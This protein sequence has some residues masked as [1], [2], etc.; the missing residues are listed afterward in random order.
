MHPFHVHLRTELLRLARSATPLQAAA[1]PDL[2]QLNKIGRRIQSVRNWEV[3][4]RPPGDYDV[5]NWIYAGREVAL[6]LDGSTT[7]LRHLLLEPGSG[8]ARLDIAISNLGP[9]AALRWRHWRVHQERLVVTTIYR[10]KSLRERLRSVRV[11]RIL[12]EHWVRVIP[13]SLLREPMPDARTAL[14]VPATLATVLFTER[15]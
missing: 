1:T 11:S 6:S 2:A 9:Y 4:V 14:D 3:E 10:P 7:E 12:T 5:C 15:W 13:A 8:L